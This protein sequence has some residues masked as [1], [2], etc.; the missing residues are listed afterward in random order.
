LELNTASEVADQ[1]SQKDLLV[2]CIGFFSFVVLGVPG[3]LLN[4]AWSPSIRDTFG[5]S[6]AAV[7]GLFLSTTTGY[8]VASSTSGRLISCLGLGWLL[9]AS[10]VV[11]VLG[12]LGYA[13]APAWWIVLLF[14]LLLGTGGGLLDGVMN[15]YFAANYGPRLMNWLHAC[16]GIGATLA[17]LAMTA[18]LKSGASWR[19][20][21]SLAALL[22]AALALLFVLTRGRWRLALGAASSAQPRMA[23]AWETLRL[24]LVW[25]GI[26]L[27]MVLT[28]LE[29]SAGQWSF[30][31]FTESRH[32][33]RE[34]AGLWIGVYWGSFTVGR[35]FFG[36]IV[37]WIRPAA[38]IRLCAAGMALGAALLWWSPR[39]GIGFLALAL[40][41]FS[42]SPLFA[43]MITTTQDRL[44]PLHAPNAIGLQV[45]AAALGV[46]VLPGLGGILAEHRGLETVPPFLLA[47][48]AVMF[49]L[50]EA[51]HHQRVEIQS[52]SA[53]RGS[54]R[55][56]H[57]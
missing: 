34:I 47:L 23:S 11:S 51:T 15:I 28:G 42:L 31:L 5:L 4:V 50:H 13:L 38:L 53:A 40:L 6:L 8:F 36:V 25:V 48:T 22:N 41:G 49:V 43:L 19:W 10:A 37:T 30:S 46:G 3:A 39:V 35:I 29:V 57:L 33:S 26:A 20:G 7:G 9:A 24:P 14:G 16:F 45:G 55:R 52:A 1:R 56:P 32:V 2:V 27:F 44:G 18:I 21:Y 12:L 54:S 17:P